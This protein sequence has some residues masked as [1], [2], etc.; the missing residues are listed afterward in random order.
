LL[1]TTLV[2]NYNINMITE[3]QLKHLAELAKIEFTED[4]LK[5]FLKDINQI[6][7]YVEE[8]QKL[9]L[10]NFEP[11][12]SGVYQQIFLREDEIERAEEDNKELIKVQFPDKKDDFLKTPRIIT[13]D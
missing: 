10:E 7:H 3:E 13:K 1:I 6:L 4:E 8:I 2:Y 12:I 9:D 5:S 11:M